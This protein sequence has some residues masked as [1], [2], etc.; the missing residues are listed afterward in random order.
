MKFLTIGMS[1]CEKKNYT[2]IF[3]IRFIVYYGEP[4]VI[5]GCGVLLG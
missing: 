2:Y 1:C 5:V 4:V 3:Y